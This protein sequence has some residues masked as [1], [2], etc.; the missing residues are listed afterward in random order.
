MTPEDGSDVNRLCALCRI[1]LSSEEKKVIGEHLHKILKYMTFLNEVDTEGVPP[2][3]H[4]L[5]TMVNVMG[6]DEE[7]VSYDR[8]KFLASA[9][10]HVGG[11]VKV[12]PVIHFE[13]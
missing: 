9:P 11:M 7:E 1:Q 5:E 8:E 4:L 6:K 12:P 3:T 13:E 10:D 2:C